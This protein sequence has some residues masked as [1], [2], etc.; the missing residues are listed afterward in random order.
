MHEKI[1]L[2]GA[3]MVMML[4]NPSKLTSTRPTQCNLGVD[5]KSGD[6]RAMAS[7]LWRHEMSSPALVT[8]LNFSSV[9]TAWPS[10]NSV[11]SI[12]VSSASACACM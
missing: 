9:S 6:K 2:A 5:A 3:R 1:L 7:V 4:G 10:F 8:S 11:S 12:L